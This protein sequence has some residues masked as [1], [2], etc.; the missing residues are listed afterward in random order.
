MHIG[1]V[2]TFGE[3]VVV[4]LENVSNEQEHI[5]KRSERIMASELIMRSQENGSIR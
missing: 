3:F 1:N 2:F 5:L 4:L